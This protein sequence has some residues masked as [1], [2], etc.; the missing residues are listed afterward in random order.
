MK[1]T[2]NFAKFILLLNF[3]FILFFFST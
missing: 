2:L 3:T 1:L